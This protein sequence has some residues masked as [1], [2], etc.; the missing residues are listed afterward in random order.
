MEHG[1]PKKVI[2]DNFTAWDRLGGGEVVC[3]ECYHVY[4]DPTYRKRAWVVTS[5]TFDEVKRENAKA[6]LLNPPDPPFVIYLTQTWKVQGFVNLINRVQ[7]STTN[8]TIGLDYK[9]IEVNTSNLA[10]YC[11][12]ISEILEKKVTKTELQTGQFKAKS[13]EKLGYDMELIEKIKQL[14]GNPLWDLAIFVS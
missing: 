12:I 1:Y 7:Q 4:T 5:T 2:S 3:P 11:N 14:A 13:Y 10:E 9:L 8:Y 6:L